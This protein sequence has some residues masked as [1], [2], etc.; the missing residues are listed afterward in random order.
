MPTVASLHVAQLLEHG[1]SHALHLIVVHHPQGQVEGVGADV[2][3]GATARF[4]LIREHAPGGNSPP[5]N[6]VGLGKVDVPPGRRC[7]RL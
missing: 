4:G 1:T 5:A 6:G 7:G 3:E 2:D